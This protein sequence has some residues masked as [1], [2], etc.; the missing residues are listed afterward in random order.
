MQIQSNQWPKLVF[1]KT[2]QYF[3]KRDVKYVKKFS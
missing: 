2:K 1:T 3:I